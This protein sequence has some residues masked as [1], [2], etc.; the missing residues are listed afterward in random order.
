MLVFNPKRIFALRG[1]E[2]PSSFLIKQGIAPSTALKFIK[3]GGSTFKTK[4]VELICVGMN[5]T[6][7]DL[8]DWYEDAKTKLPENHPLRALERKQKINNIREMLHDLPVEKLSEL[9]G[10][11]NNLKESA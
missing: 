6:P 2:K 9:E 5:C 10:L 1:V 3:A 8:F 4:Y 7:N 11:I